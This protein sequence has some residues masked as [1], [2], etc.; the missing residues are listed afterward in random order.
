MCITFRMQYHK[1]T[2]A[3]PNLN[4]NA[5]RNQQMSGVDEEIFK[6]EVCATN[7]DVSWHTKSCKEE[8][9]FK[10]DFHNII[11]RNVS[12]K[13]RLSRI[14]CDSDFSQSRHCLCN[15][16]IQLKLFGASHMRYNFDYFLKQCGLVK[17]FRAYHRDMYINNVAYIEN[18][19][20]V[21][22]YGRISKSIF[23]AT[24]L[25]AT[26]VNAASNYKVLQ[27]GAHDLGFRPHYDFMSDLLRT[28]PVNMPHVFQE[29]QQYI[30]FT[31]MPYEQIRR[32][33][34]YWNFYIASAANYFI[35]REL[36][37][38]REDI[39]VFDIY[40]IILPR[41]SEAL[42]NGHYFCVQKDNGT[43]DGDVGYEYMYY[44]TNHLCKRHE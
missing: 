3:L 1:N 13:W 26:G 15:T 22:L 35:R 36:R 18:G 27:F 40:K 31:I 6:T 20:L 43:L 23:N 21:D 28:F 12:G 4:F 5:Y 44:F 19:Y 29:D 16:N 34:N 10:D 14:D 41:F 38:M 32:H 39:D 17:T 30:Y 7:Y 11:W 9:W 8:K 42:C 24:S 33:V 2:T 25:S 37:N